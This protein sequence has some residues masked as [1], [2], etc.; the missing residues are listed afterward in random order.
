MRQ[1]LLTAFLL[2]SILTKAQFIKGDKVLGGTFSLYSQD[3]DSQNGGLTSNVKSISITPRLGFLL[4]EN[5]SI[6]GQLGLGYT[7]QETTSFEYKSK[8]ISLG[9][10][11][12]RY[13]NI[14]DKFLFSV[15]GQFNF[16]RGQETYPYFDPFLGEVIGKKTQNYTLTAS[17][18]P[19]FTFFPSP[20]WGFEA[21]IGLISYSY[22]RSLSTDEKANFASLNYGS[23]EMV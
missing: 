23:I 13:F 12:Q 20:K 11:G 22:L 7:K 18:R 3:A 14:T 1:I 16:A 9:L 5:F 17:I 10:F 19:N 21:G 8:S 2:T 6:G 15:I 4:N